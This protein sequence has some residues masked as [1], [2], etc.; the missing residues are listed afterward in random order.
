MV[1]AGSAFDSARAHHEP[2]IVV[3]G[4]SGVPVI[5]DG[6]VR[7]KGGKLTFP[8]DVLRRRMDELTKSGARIMREG[9]Y[10]VGAA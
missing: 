8:A 9:G 10:T 2:V 4:R 6:V 5:I 7:K 1:L 3:P